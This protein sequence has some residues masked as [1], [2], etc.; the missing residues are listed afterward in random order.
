MITM[1]RLETLRGADVYDAEGDKIGSVEE[2]FV[3]EQTQEP[4]WIGLGTG[5]FGTKRVLV[6]AQTAEYAKDAVS[7]PYSKNQVKNT[8]DIDDDHID[9][10]TEAELYSHY[11]LEYSEQ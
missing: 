2:V 4:E 6:P 3:D 5:L 9:Q 1:D 11:G 8:P 10:G 7:V